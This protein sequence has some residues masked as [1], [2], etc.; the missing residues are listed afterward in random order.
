MAAAMAGSLYDFGGS[1]GGGVSGIAER[2]LPPDI[3]LGLG[4]NIE[5]IDPADVTEEIEDLLGRTG[6]LGRSGGGG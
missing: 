3:G 1:G 5:D 6:R 4:G 2:D